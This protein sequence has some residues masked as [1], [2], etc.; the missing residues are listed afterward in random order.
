ME[1]TSRVSQTESQNQ[2]VFSFAKNVLEEVR[3][4]L[5]TFPKRPKVKY[6][7]LRIWETEG[8][9]SPG[10][11]KPTHRG[12][13]IDAELLPSV[14]AAVEAAIAAVKKEDASA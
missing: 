11:E 13:C 1:G 4:N 14:L 12:I 3:A 9:S 10:R 8:M 6:F 7:D 2:L 5:V